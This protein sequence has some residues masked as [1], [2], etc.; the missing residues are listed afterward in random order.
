MRV[1][2]PSPAFQTLFDRFDEAGGVV[3]VIVHEGVGAAASPEA[4]EVVA[5]LQS[6]D[7]GI[8]APRELRQAD[9]S[10][11]LAESGGQRHAHAR[12]GDDASQLT[13][14]LAR[15]APAIV[16]AKQAAAQRTLAILERE[17][18]LRPFLAG[19]AYTIA[20][21]AVFAY[22]SRAEE[23]GL[24]LDAYPQLRAWIARVAAQPGHLAEMHPYRLDPHSSGELP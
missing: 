14:K 4:H 21:I 24:V 7:D 17:L 20:D 5:R 10:A 1:V 3:E 18:S 2:P 22:G 19:E 8:H 15:R 12:L 6:R 13:G 9:V 16:E 11:R 23:A